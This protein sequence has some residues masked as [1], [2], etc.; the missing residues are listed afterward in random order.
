MA[1]RELSLLYQQI[2]KKDKMY[3]KLDEKLLEIKS[4]GLL[5]LVRTVIR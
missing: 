1:Q 2:Q 3:K 5:R 4:F